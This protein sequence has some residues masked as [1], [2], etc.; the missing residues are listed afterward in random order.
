[1]R[2]EMDAGDKNQQAL[3]LLSDARQLCLS[4]LVAIARV[5][6]AKNVQY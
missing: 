4:R 5:I 2:R 1:M 3:R 6:E